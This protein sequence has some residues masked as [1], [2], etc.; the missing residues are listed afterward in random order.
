MNLID[1]LSA[2]IVTIK[3]TAPFNSGS[4]L[5]LSIVQAIA[6]THKGAVSI[7]VKDEY[8][9]EVTVELLLA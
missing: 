8:Y 2:F 9:F 4:G 5:G 7:T 6:N 3:P 1:Y